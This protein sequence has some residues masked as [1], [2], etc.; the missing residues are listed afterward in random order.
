MKMKVWRKIMLFSLGGTGYMGL[1]L[2]WRGWTHGSMFLAGGTAFL[3]LGEID[4]HR[5]PVLPKMLLGALCITGVELVSGLLVN[6][7]HQVW[8]YSGLPLSLAGQICL[9]FALLWMGLTIPG[10][11]LFR[12]LDYR[13]PA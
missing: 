1:E 3:L 12:V 8:D 4:R 10:C 9:P 7:N 13:L 11:I 6:R 5:F 2:L